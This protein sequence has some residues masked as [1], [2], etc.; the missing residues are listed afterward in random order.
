MEDDQR[1]IASSENSYVVMQNELEEG[2]G[3]KHDDE[4][5]KVEQQKQKQE[6]EE[7]EKAEEER[8]AEIMMEQ[9]NGIE[10]NNKNENDEQRVVDMMNAANEQEAQSTAKRI[11]NSVCDWQQQQHHSF[12]LSMMTSHYE[13]PSLGE[14]V[15]QCMGHIGKLQKDMENLPVKN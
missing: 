10:N 13:Y 7:E 2:E 5:V 9:P 11:S 12:D 3:A 15:Q 4:E 14:Q 6:T 8:P 1:S